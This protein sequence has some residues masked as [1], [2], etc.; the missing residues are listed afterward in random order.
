MSAYL[1]GCLIH[2]GDGLSSG[3][4]P[5]APMV[6]Q[7]LPLSLGRVGSAV[8][9]SFYCSFF[10]P[11]LPWETDQ[12]VL[13]FDF[14][15]CVSLRQKVYSLLPRRLRKEVMIWVL[16]FLHCWIEGQVTELLQVRMHIP[17]INS[18]KRGYE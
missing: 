10:Q 5:L 7:D 15:L 4:C 9:M 13:S 6:K 12:L 16:C 14:F 11:P 8:I 18:D 3:L 17:R 1:L 2:T